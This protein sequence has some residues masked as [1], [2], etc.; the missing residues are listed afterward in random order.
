MG[1]VVLVLSGIRA[2]LLF[3]NRYTCSAAHLGVPGGWIAYA[4]AR[5][6][7]LGIGSIGDVLEACDHGKIC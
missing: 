2:L 7:L 6:V 3:V 1:L 4:Q 5:I